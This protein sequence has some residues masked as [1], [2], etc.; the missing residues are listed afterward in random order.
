MKG[1]TGV[2]EGRGRLRGMS[3]TPSGRRER[4]PRAPSVLRRARSAVAS[5]AVSRPTGSAARARSCARS[6]S[7]GSSR[8]W[9]FR[10]RSAIGRV[11]RVKTT[12]RCGVRFVQR[13]AIHPGNLRRDVLFLARELG[14]T[15]LSANR[16]A[17]SQP[18]GRVSSP[19]MYDCD[20]IT[21]PIVPVQ[22]TPRDSLAVSTERKAEERSS[23][24]GGPHAVQPRRTRLPSGATQAGDAQLFTQRPSRR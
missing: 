2:G 5:P 4:R 16:A 15:P 11:R 10:S 14:R 9:R 6:G 13:H 22:H 18:P 17:S 7:P 20:T 3:Q 23:P 19:P 1:R 12:R 21:R 24:R 8:C